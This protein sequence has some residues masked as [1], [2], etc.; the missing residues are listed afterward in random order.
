M[1][2]S[3]S[4]R[5]VFAR[6]RSP[7]IQEEENNPPISKEAE[8]LLERLKNTHWNT[9]RINGVKECATKNAHIF[10]MIVNGPR[11]DYQAPQRGQDALRHLAENPHV[12]DAVM[13]EE[14]DDTVPLP[15]A[16]LEAMREGKARELP[17]IPGRELEE[18]EEEYHD[19]VKRVLMRGVTSMTLEEED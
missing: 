5:I 1:S 19:R 4:R 6:R 9:H 17:I 8:I 10:N 15:P 3:S 12:F 11:Y 18:D 13:N 7:T 16:I 14:G 2:S